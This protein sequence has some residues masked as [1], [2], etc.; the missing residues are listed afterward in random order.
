LVS[1]KGIAIMAAIVAGVGGASAVIWLGPQGGE[2]GGTNIV[3][4]VNSGNINRFSSSDVL[5][6]IYARQQNLATEMELQYEDWKAGDIDSDTLVSDID[7]ARSEA[8]EMRDALASA[9]P[10]QEWQAS[11]DLYGDA[12]DSFLLYLDEMEGIVEAGD[13]DPDEEALLLYKQDS[14]DLVE[15]AIAAIPA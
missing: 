15:Q 8:E 11:Y 14:D 13:R 9:S 1:A 7:D 6:S 10:P 12:L 4:D 2:P 5:S 3:P